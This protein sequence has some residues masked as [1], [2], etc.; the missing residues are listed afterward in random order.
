LIQALVACAWGQ[1]AA[2]PTTTLTVGAATVTVEI[3]D[4]PA[5][6]ERGLM[7]RES[8]ATDHGMLFVYPNERQR[9]FWM[10][11]TSLPLS[12]AYLDAQGRI[13]R[14]A[15][16]TPFDSSPVPSGRPAMYALEVRQGWFQQHAI[17]VGTAVTGLPPAS[18]H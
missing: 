14:I 13:V 4:D 1:S 9:S 11:D 7:K 6:R 10:K 15:D 3:A 12:I 18:A 2:L 17:Q 16:M 8:L 5:E